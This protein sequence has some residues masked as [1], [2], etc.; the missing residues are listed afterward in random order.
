MIPGVTTYHP[1]SAW[2]EN[3]FRME[4]DF[5]SVPGS[6]QA[7]VIRLGVCHY[8]S[9][10]DLPDG[11]IEEFDYQIVPWLRASQRDY[12]NRHEGSG[13]TR[14]SDG[15][16]FPGYPLGYSFAVDWLGGVWELRGFT[17]RPAATSGHNHYT[18]PILMI[19][20][21]YDPATDLQWRSARAVWRQTKY[22]SNRTDFANRPLGHG[23]LNATQC[24]GTA[25]LDQLH[26]GLGDLDYNEQ[27]DDMGNANVG[28]VRLKGFQDQFALI[29]LD[30]GTNKRM[31][32]ETTPALVIT[33]G[34][35]EATLEGQ[36]GYQLT[37]TADGS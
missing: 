8:S 31:G 1:R 36:V 32:L 37:P 20:D 3:G 11:D 33:A 25:L 16:F 28:K 30:A 26:L 17:Y 6:Y 24:P 12:Y 4:S 15:R 2:Q 19:T 9:A 35:T 23:E 34:I 21:R 7:S 14:K 10:M 13:Y 29:P 27:E 5:T 18:L 22:L